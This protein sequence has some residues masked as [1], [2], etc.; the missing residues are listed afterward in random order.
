MRLTVRL[1]GPEAKA[2]GTSS[3]TVDAPRGRMT[4]A[5]LR[6]LLARAEPRLAASLRS[7]RFAV[8]HAFADDDITV[9]DEDEIA[10]IGMVSGG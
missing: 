5:E 2:V 7:A 4:C 1:F 6:A 9:G 8:N 10:I 3:I